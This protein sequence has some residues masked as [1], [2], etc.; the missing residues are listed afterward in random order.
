MGGGETR[1][2]QFSKIVESGGWGCKN[3]KKYTYVTGIKNTP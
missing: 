2:G 3:A 1:E